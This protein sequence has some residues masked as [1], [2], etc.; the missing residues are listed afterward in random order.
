MRFLRALQALCAGPLLLLHVSAGALQLTTVASSLSSP[1]FVGHAGDGSNRLFIVEQTGTIRVLQPGAVTTTV[2]LDIHTRLVS[3]GEQGLLGLAFHPRYPVNGRFFVFYTRPADGALVIAE[4]RVSA[5]PNVASTDE[6]ILLTIPHPGFGNHN[7]GM[8]AFG[9][10]GYLYIG[11]GDGGSGNDPPNNAQN[12]ETLLGKIL[13]IDV[14]H[15]DIV[16]GTVYSSPADNPYVGKAGRDEVFSLGWRNPWRFSFDRVSRAQWVADVGQG[17]HEEVDSPIVKGGN[18]GWRI[19]E[20]FACTNIDPLLCNSTYIYPNFEYT[21]S[22]GRCSIT[23]GYAYR[24]GSG[25]L[26]AGTYVYG[27]YCTGELFGWNGVTQS[28][29][30]DTPMNISAF[31]EDEVGELYVVNHGG[32]VRKLV[33]TVA[34]GYPLIQGA[35]SRKTH[36]ASAFDLPLSLVAFNP[37]TEPRSA[38]T[39][40]IVIAFDKPVASASAFMTEGAAIVGT[41]IVNGSEVAV[42]L[43]AVADA[44]YLTLSLTNV[45][46][47]NGIGGG[48]GSV[49]LGFLGGD[50]D[51]NRSVT[52]S[53][54]LAV[55]AVLTQTVNG[56]NYLKDVNGS[57]SLSVSDLLV[58]NSRLTQTLRAP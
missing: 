16:A 37:T 10:D 14:D 40:S 58:V 5:N 26:P 3:G 15:S 34:P 44:Q 24:G 54:L 12:I 57:G 56:S 46:G 31:G 38:V 18:Y 36:G 52:L 2:F 1:V 11:V 51:A 4:Y 42:P 25:A 45:T 27:D 19:Y 17:S 47:T 32:D 49:R 43:T 35:R 39:A 53:D 22:D 30:L 41:P 55:N 33:P 6:T 8:L 50:V 21:H 7:G 23:G 9:P 28:L 48:S 13:R 20:G 29:L